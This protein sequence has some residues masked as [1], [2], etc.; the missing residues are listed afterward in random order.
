MDIDEADFRH[1]AAAAEAAP[2]PY[3][4]D[5]WQARTTTELREIIKRGFSIGLAYDGAVAETE[6]RARETMARLREEAKINDRRKAT[7]RLI[8]LAALLLVI[9]AVGLLDFRL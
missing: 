9:L 1:A 2:E 5:W 7:Y 3:S 6:R 8:V 4:A